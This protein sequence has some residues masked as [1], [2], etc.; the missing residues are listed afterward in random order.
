MMRLKSS[1]NSIQKVQFIFISIL[2]LLN[3]TQ[4]LTLPLIDD[5]AYYWVWSK[6]L[7]FGYFDHPPMVAV[8][9]KLGY[10]LFPNM[11]GVRIV[12]ALSNVLFYILWIYILKPKTLQENYLLLGL[13][14]SSAIFQGLGFIST[15]D[16]PLLLFGTFFLWRWKEFLCIQNFK[17]TFLLALSMALTMYSKYQ[18]I[19]IIVCAILPSIPI[20]FKN[21]W[22]YLSILF[23]IILYSPHLYWQYISNWPSV[24]Y[25]IYERTQKVVKGFL[26]GEWLL[27]ILVISN[28]LLIYFYFKSLIIKSNFKDLL[29][30]KSL[31]WVSIGSIIFFGFFSFS[32]KIQPQWNLVVYMALIPLCFLFYRKKISKYLLRIC[33]FSLFLFIVIR[34]SFLSPIIISYT[35][36]YK[37]KKFVLHAE[38]VNRGIAVFER[39]QKAALFN[40]YTQKPSVA[41]Q[42]YTHR[43]SQYDLWNSENYLNGKN[44]TFFGLEHTSNH[45]ILDESNKKEYYKYISNFHSYSNISCQ[46]NF[47]KSYLDSAKILHLYLK[48][49][50]PYEKNFILENNS[51]LE[52]GIMLTDKKSLEPKIFLPFA[53]SIQILH[54]NSDEK[55]FLFDLSSC[56]ANQYR[57]YIVIKPCGISGK[58]ISEGMNINISNL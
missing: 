54:G 6:R 28:P 21:K 17:T 26:P 10:A 31:Q 48:W 4:A 14:G 30:V 7:D 49:Q 44:I 27:G 16:T 1:V 32:R 9:I 11:L 33:Y 34:I 29:W 47:N 55:L 39:Y 40:F 41:L 24:R 18:G 35:P 19:I 20:L 36:M 22:F 5:E 37:I 46:I 38:E 52:G 56:A 15:P 8:F 51:A 3:L 12:S 58:N 53:Q 23:S 13:L 45:F 43:K 42:I 25:H 57:I 50:N 2:F